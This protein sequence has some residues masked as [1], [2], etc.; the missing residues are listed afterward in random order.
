[1]QPI[2]N[3][4]EDE[5]FVFHKGI[6]AREMLPGPDTCIDL[7]VGETF[8]FFLAALRAWKAMRICCFNLFIYLFISFSS[9]AT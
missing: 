5:D 7:P 1:M 6:F 4:R 3:I 2:K 8:F 9:W